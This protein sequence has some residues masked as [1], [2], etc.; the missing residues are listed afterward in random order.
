MDYTG[1]VLHADSLIVLTVFAFCSQLYP[2]E[3]LV[4]P[5]LFP[6]ACV[7]I[8]LHQEVINAT[9]VIGQPVPEKSKHIKFS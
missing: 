4:I 3:C 2:G 8:T 7:L 1:S 5:V 9:I 6:C